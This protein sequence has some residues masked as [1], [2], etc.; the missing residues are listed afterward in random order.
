MKKVFQ[1]WRT[2]FDSKKNIF[3]NISKICFLLEK[4]FLVCLINFPVIRWKVTSVEK[5]YLHISILFKNHIKTYK[6][7]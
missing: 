3:L 5:L 6:K 4:L 7:Y 1:H 2:F